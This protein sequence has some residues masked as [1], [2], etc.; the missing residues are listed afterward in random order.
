MTLRT[1]ERT[2]LAPFLPGWECHLAAA[3]LACGEDGWHLLSIYRR[4]HPELGDVPVRY[5]RARC[6]NDDDCHAERI[7]AYIV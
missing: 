7:H 2:T 3:T 5:D 1:P 6:R 4:M